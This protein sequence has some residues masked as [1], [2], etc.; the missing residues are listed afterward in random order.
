MAKTKFNGPRHS[1]LRMFLATIENKFCLWQ[2]KVS[3]QTI[4]ET[5]FLNSRVVIFAFYEPDGWD[6]WLPGAEDKTEPAFAEI[7]RAV[8]LDP[9]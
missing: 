7:Q 8:G 4:F 3:S 1:E 6:V 2:H 5:W 9:V